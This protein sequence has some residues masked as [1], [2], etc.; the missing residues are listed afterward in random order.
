LVYCETDPALSG[1][2]GLISM[3]KPEQYNLPLQCCNLSVCKK[4][5][6]E[7]KNGNTLEY[8][9]LLIAE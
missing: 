4:K 2:T 5:R 3:L 1:V 8:C 7:K 9:I 6:K